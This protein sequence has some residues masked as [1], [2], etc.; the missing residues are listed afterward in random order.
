MSQN[1]NSPF[2]TS[3][4]TQA[5]QGQPAGPPQVGDLYQANKAASQQVLDY[6]KMM[7]ALGMTPLPKA[8]SSGS[9]GI[10]GPPLLLLTLLIVPPVAA[11]LYD[12]LWH[13]GNMLIFS[14]LAFGLLVG[15][16][17]YPAIH[18]GKVRNKAM[19]VIMGAIIGFAA[20]VGAMGLEAWGY[21]SQFVDYD[22]ASLVKSKGVQ[23][24]QARQMA[25]AYYTP[26]NMTKTYWEERSAAGM[27]ITS[28]KTRS[29]SQISGTIFWV[30][31]GLELGLA[32][33]IT[34]G[35]AAFFAGRRY[36]DEF[37]RWYNTKLLGSVHAANF[38]ELMNAANSG[39]W[40]KVRACI[41]SEKSSSQVGAQLDVAY[42]PEKPGGWLTISAKV[43]KNKGLQPIFTQELTNEEMK[44]AW[45]A[46]PA[47]A[48]S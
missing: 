20:F 23:P 48:N 47:P 41:G 24:Q 44:A 16:A 40:A 27:T 43:H 7:P 35:L 33:L 14:A 29:Q 19:A 2:E 17:M 32:T 38:Q 31:Q 13:F 11:L 3:T 34:A 5:P 36:S 10:M 15:F 28:S 39:D 12:K 22:V 21:R 18:F 46:F 6:Q 42:L 9:F 25:E 30:L 45:P 1:S 4:S 37:D 26:F 8:K